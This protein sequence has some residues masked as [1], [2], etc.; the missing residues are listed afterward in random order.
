MSSIA[1]IEGANIAILKRFKR[2]LL[3]ELLPELQKVFNSVSLLF[4]LFFCLIFTLSVLS[5]LIFLLIILVFS[6][7]MHTDQ[8][9]PDLAHILSLVYSLS[10]YMP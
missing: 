2:E 4:D 5:V 1:N 3:L 9:E 7:C 6:F 8:D 10:L